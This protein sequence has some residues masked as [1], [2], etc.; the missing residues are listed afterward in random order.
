M[1]CKLCWSNLILLFWR[2][3]GAAPFYYLCWTPPAFILIW[4]VAS[5]Q[6]YLLWIFELLKTFECFFQLLLINGEIKKLIF[7]L[8][9]NDNLINFYCFYSKN[10]RLKLCL[11]RRCRKNLLLLVLNIGHHVFLKFWN[12]IS[13]MFFFYFKTKK[14][15]QCIIIFVFTRFYQ[16]KNY[17][18]LIKNRIFI[19]FIFLII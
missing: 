4:L 16:T 1:F 15:L 2:G 8:K 6:P 11:W 12:Q 7:F 10:Q 13:Q 17:V 19:K 14:K 5:E 3:F 9:K 18:W